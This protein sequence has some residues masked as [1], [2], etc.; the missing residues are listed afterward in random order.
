MLLCTRVHVQYPAFAPR[1]SE[2]ALGGFGS[3]LSFIQN[4]SQLHMHTVLFIPIRFLCILWLK[5]RC[6]QVRLLSLFSHS[7]VSSSFVTP[8]TVACQAPLSMDFLGKNSGEGCHFLLQRIFLT[9]RLNPCLL[10]RQEDCL[11]LS[12]LGSPSRYRH[13]SKGSQILDLSHNLFVCLP[14]LLQNQSPRVSPLLLYS[15]VLVTRRR[16][17]NEV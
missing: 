3:L 13:S 8:Q 7:V 11:P 10:H 14:S 17:L 4:S 12:H 9:Q 1:S 2:V 5:E 15:S 6:V 16:I